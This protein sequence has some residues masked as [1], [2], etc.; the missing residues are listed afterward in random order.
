LIE[1]AEA[2]VDEAEQIG[3]RVLQAE[4]AGELAQAC[5]SPGGRQVPDP[6]HDRN[7]GEDTAEDKQRHVATIGGSRSTG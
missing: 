2:V 3:R 1:Q 4:P 7:E 5:P 6:G